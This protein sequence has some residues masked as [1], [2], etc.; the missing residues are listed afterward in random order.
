M[1]SINT[2][3]DNSV[4]KLQNYMLNIK[5][6]TRIINS[7]IIY[8]KKKSEPIKKIVLKNT[9]SF[10]YPEEKDSLFWCY[11]IIQNGFSKYEHPQTT[12]FVNEK[13]EKFKCIESMRKNKQQLK[14]KKIKNIKE[15]VE[16]ELA[17]KTCIKMKTFIALCVSSN[18]NIMYICKRKCFEIIFD[19]ENPIHVIHEIT[20]TQYG[21]EQ[22]CS[23]EKI[24]KYR[25]ELFKWESVDKP[26]KAI[27][28][29]KS[30]ELI[31]LCKKMDLSSEICGLKKKTKKELYELLVT[32]L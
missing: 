22:D 1:H 23:K 11:Y 16:D 30:E 4:N 32:N 24:N 7:S 8:E 17:N 29:Y 14:L 31:E 25:T 10:F 3:K 18:I 26:L 12:S 15:D 9:E 5:N 28:S 27:S 6:I 13:L 19:L 2:S 20:H 21:Y